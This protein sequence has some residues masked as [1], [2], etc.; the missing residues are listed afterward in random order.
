[1]GDPAGRETASSC[2]SL[3]AALSSGRLQ[4]VPDAEPRAGLGQ[5]AHPRPVDSEAPDCS[6]T[7]LQGVKVGRVGDVLPSMQ[8]ESPLVS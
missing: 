6:G 2:P 8:P 1:M 7:P 5:P 4:P 3:A